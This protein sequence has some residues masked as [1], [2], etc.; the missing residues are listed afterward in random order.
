MQY[1]HRHN[2]W[3]PL[4]NFHFGEAKREVGGI[5]KKDDTSEMRYLTGPWVQAWVE[6][7]SPPP[8]RGAAGAG[9]VNR[10]AVALLN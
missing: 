10:R 7:S 3:S 1:R 2:F 5:E 4:R 8:S 6:T 9:K